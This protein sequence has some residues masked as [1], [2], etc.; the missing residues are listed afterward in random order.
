[1]KNRDLIKDI[2]E[3]YQLLEEKECSGYFL[4]LSFD[5]GTGFTR[6]QAVDFLRLSGLVRMMSTDMELAMLEALHEVSGVSVNDDLLKNINKDTM[7]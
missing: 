7:N 5:E 1:M 2:K 4:C 3:I 6:Y